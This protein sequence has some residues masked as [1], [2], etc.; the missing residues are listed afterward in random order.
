MDQIVCNFIENGIAEFTT[1]DH[2]YRLCHGDIQDAK[3]LFEIQEKLPLDIYIPSSEEEIASAAQNKE[4]YIIKTDDTPIAFMIF[5]LNGIAS[6][7]SEFTDAENFA[8]VDAVYVD[9]SCRGNH[10]QMLFLHLARRLGEINKIN[11]LVATVS[12]K[13]R[14]SFINFENAGYDVVKRVKY[15]LPQRAESRLFVMKKLNYE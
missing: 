11:C 8:V 2:E 9:K 7:Y 10:F 5:L 13:N 6:S 4:L 3:A 12:E 15:K 14:H 1:S